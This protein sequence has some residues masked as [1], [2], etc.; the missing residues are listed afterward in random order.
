MCL[1]LEPAVFWPHP[2]AM[3]WVIGTLARQLWAVAGSNQQAS[4]ADPVPALVNYNM[5]TAG[6]R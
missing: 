4:Q 6:T 1:R 3:T 2:S 5:P